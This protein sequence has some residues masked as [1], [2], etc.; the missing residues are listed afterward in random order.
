[1]GATMNKQGIMTR[2]LL[3]LI[4]ALIIF[5]PACVLSE[6]LFRTSTQA[7]DNFESFARELEDFAINARFQQQTSEL[8]IMD[9]QTAIVYFTD[10]ASRITFAADAKF[11][12]PDYQLFFDRPLQCDDN[13]NCL[14][15]FRSVDFAESSGGEIVVIPERL[16]CRSFDYSVELESC[17]LGQPHDIDTA[18]CTG[19]FVIERNLAKDASWALDSY[20]ENPRR[21][22]IH[23]VKTGE[24][25]R[26]YE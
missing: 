8:L 16:L 18:R 15:L 7:Q 22:T 1:M 25:V 6:R 24:T 2:F 19:G 23:F 10:N 21:R 11:P 3:G 17:A 5:L 9:E 14:C 4:L 26:L 20:Y 13:S 12:I